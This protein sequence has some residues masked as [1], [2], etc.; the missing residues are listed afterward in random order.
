QPT[1]ENQAADQGTQQSSPPPSRRD[2]DR[3]A[4]ASIEQ[5]R[6]IAA[7]TATSRRWKK[8]KK[9][10]QPTPGEESKA[11]AQCRRPE[12]NNPDL[13]PLSTASRIPDRAGSLDLNSL[14]CNTEERDR[15]FA[16][17]APA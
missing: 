11:P 3:R 17:K 15:A 12:E 7:A 9:K 14:E 6:P 2:R 16:G 5:P 8:K 10:G 4:A 1:P 13:P